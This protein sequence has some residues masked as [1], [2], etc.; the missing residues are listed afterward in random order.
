MQPDAMTRSRW[1]AVTL[2]LFVAACHCN[3]RPDFTPAAQEIVARH[4]NSAL[5]AFCDREGDAEPLGRFL[6]A[7]K[8][9][10]TRADLVQAWD[11]IPALKIKRKQ[12]L[13]SR[14]FAKALKDNSWPKQPVDEKDT[15]V[16]GTRAAVQDFL[17][18]EG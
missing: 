8:G 10:Q 5:E 13:E 17:K 12:F 11:A 9:A 1:H 7:T 6:A 3:N 2:V 16:D 4:A 18:G 15:F 14:V